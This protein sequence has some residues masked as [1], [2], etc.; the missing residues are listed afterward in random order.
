[1]QD[2]WRPDD[3]WQVSDG[4]RWDYKS[5]A[6]NEKFVTPPDV[7]AALRAYPGWKAAGINPERLYFDRPQP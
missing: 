5:N 3:H 2:D 1:M 7:V 6:K 4:L